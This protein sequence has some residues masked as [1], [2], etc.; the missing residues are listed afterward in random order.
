MGIKCPRYGDISYGDIMPKLWGYKLW[1]YKLWGYNAHLI[2]CPTVFILERT[3]TWTYMYNNLIIV[4]HL[5][6]RGLKVFY[7]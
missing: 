2:S 4:E 1:E 6:Q 7:Y 3:V 5:L